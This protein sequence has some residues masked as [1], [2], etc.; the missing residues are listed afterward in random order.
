MAH[1][2][3]DEW[4]NNNKITAANAVAAANAAAAAANAPANVAAAAVAAAEADNVYTEQEIRDDYIDFGYYLFEE[5]DA[6]E[7]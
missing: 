4:I 5:I 7:E 1:N 6:G 3:R 2:L